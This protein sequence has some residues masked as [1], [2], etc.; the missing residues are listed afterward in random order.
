MSRFS[1]SLDQDD[2]Q[3][4]PEELDLSGHTELCGG[5]LLLQ[6]VFVSI[7]YLIGLL[8]SQNTAFIMSVGK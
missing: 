7:S 4:D 5:K 6:C 2:L 8:S 3:D 1:G